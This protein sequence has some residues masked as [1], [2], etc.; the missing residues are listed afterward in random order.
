[1]KKVRLISFICK[2]EELT[3]RLNEEWKRLESL[4]KTGKETA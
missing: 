2:A 1:M 3:T 4:K